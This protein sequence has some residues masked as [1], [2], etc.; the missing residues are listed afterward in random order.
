MNGEN[1][2]GGL[3]GQPVTIAEESS[4]YGNGVESGADIVAD[5]LL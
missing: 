5:E 1:V 2:E 4:L 3:L